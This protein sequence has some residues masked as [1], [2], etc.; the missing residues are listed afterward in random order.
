LG[1]SIT[2][3]CI[4][5]GFPSKFEHFHSDIGLQASSGRP[6]EEGLNLQKKGLGACSI[7]VRVSGFIPYVAMQAIFMSWM[8]CL[9]Y[10][11]S[12][13]LS[14]PIAMPMASPRLH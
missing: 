5:T 12:E 10:G 7:L 13:W 9:G 1:E 8:I 14:V 6:G 4:K 11:S 3:T 2:K